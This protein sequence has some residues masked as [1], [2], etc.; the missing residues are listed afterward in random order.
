V[1]DFLVQPVRKSLPCLSDG[2][3]LIDLIELRFNSHA[4]QNFIFIIN[5][6]TKEPGLVT[7]CNIQHESGAALFSEKI[8]KKVNK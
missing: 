2:G 5:L 4:I 6:K 8:S 3:L 7:S 1:H